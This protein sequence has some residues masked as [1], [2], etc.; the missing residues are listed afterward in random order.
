[1]DSNKLQILQYKMKVY[2]KQV[3]VFEIGI[4]DCD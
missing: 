1:M 2:Q 4:G 3:L